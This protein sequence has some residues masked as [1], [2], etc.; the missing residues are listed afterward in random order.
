MI[1]WKEGKSLQI[2]ALNLV[3]P[4]NKSSPAYYSTPYSDFSETKGGG[5][6]ISLRGLEVI[7]WSGETHKLITVTL[8]LASCCGPAGAS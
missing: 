4:I 3:L 6:G 5:Q 8:Q 1:D 7:Q 2:H